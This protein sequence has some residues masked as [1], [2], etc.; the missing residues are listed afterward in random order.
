MQWHVVYNPTDTPNP[1]VD[2]NVEPPQLLL[3]AR[4][5]T[6]KEVGEM[7]GTL[8]ALIIPSVLAQP[9]THVWVVEYDVDYAGHW[10]E[11][12]EQFRENTADLLTTTIVSKEKCEDWYWWESARVPH[13]IESRF[14]LRAFQPIM[15]LSRS[16]ARAYVDE[17][18]IPGWQGHYEFT[19]PTVAAFYGFSIEDIGSTGEYCPRSRYGMNYSNNPNDPR[20]YPGTF[21]WRPERTSYFSEAPQ[22]FEQLNMLYHPVKPDEQPTS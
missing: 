1:I 21:V 10:Y 2:F 7:A 16:F 8:D 15:R 12:F 13:D 18:A 17:M 6:I 19:F 14:L 3:P 20:L 5:D 4:Y 9:A 11:F 22:T